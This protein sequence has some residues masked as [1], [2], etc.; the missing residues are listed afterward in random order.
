MQTTKETLASEIIKQEKKK[1][2]FWKVATITALVVI[3]I[4]T[5][6]ILF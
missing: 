2:I 4:E 3:A 6:F 5:A 1:V